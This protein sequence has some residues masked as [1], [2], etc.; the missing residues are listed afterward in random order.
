MRFAIWRL[1][2]SFAAAVLVFLFWLPKSLVAQAP[3]HL[4]SPSDLQNAAVDASNARQK[5]VDTLNNVFSSEQGQQALKSAH[6]NPE[7]VKSAVA[8]LSDQELAQLASRAQK[9]QA[10]FAA[11]SLDNHDLL[12]I[13]LCIAVL[14]LI[15]VAV[16]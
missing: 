16:H 10:D 4:V 14:I 8:G 11:G 1:G 9:A 6:I 3:Q 12:I 7:Q 13:L 5:N 2:R 15:I